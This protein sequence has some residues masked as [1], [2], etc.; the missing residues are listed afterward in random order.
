MKAKAKIA[1]SLA[2]FIISYGAIV[3]TVLA[4]ASKCCCST[5]EVTE[6]LEKE[7]KKADTKLNQVYRK[8]LSQRKDQDK[9]QNK[10][11]LPGGASA[12][13][14]DALQ[15]AQ[16]AWIKFRDA[17]CEFRH[18]LSYPGTGASLDYGDCIVKMTEERTSELKKEIK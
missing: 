3:A 4:D 7:T 11:G 15:K 9:E 10:V 2:V 6:C 12:Y 16:R 18:S 14:A 17:N 8:L 1:F 13:S 5:V